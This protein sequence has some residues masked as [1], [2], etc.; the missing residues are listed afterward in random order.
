MNLKDKTIGFALTGSFCTLEAAV[1][2][3]EGIIAAGANVLPIISN[4]VNDM[5]TRFGKADVL[6]DRLVRI[7]GNQIIKTVPQAEP[8]G[9]KGLL[10]I[11]VVCPCTG[12]TLAKIAA[13]VTDNSVTMAVKAHLR[14]DRPVVIAISTN[15]GLS[16]NAQNIGKLLNSKNIYFVPFG[17]DDPVGKKT[18][19]VAKNELV[20]ET[21]ELALEKIQLQPLLQ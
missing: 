9:P 21:L 19:L 3:L 4:N 7:T 11:L 20:A 2:Q 10:D 8:I 12:N 18:S 14:N 13:G 6:K 1:T 17:Q 16:G 5:D 15:D